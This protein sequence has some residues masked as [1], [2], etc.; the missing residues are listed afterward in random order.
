MNTARKWDFLKSKLTLV[1]FAINLSCQL[2]RILYKFIFVSVVIRGKLDCSEKAFNMRTYIG[3]RLLNLALQ[4]QIYRAGSA[5]G[6]LNFSFMPEMSMLRTTT[7][8]SLHFCL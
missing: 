2:I 3:S 7:M 8:A 6:N 4:S 5:T 1:D